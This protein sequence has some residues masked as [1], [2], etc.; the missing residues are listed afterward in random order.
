[1]TDNHSPDL[2][3]CQYTI[4]GVPA[5]LTPQYLE[6][7]SKFK[8]ASTPDEKVACLETMLRLIPKHK[9]TEK[10]Q[11]DLKR[12]LSKLRK[13]SQRKS[14]PSPRQPYY[15]IE[16]EG[17]GQAILCGPPNGGKS[18]LLD[19]LTQASPEIGDYPFTTRVPQPGMMQFEDIQIQLVDTPAL[20]P[21][22]LESWQMTMIA[23]A[24]VAV[25][26]FDVCDPQLLEQTDFVVEICEE[27]NILLNST[28]SKPR[29]VVLGN[30]LDQPLAGENFR[31]W[32]ELYQD[33]FTARP[34]S[35]RQNEHLK[36]FK[37]LL[38][39]LL[40][41]VRVYTK[42]PG[43]KRDEGSQPYLLKCGSTV[44]DAACAVHK[45]LV[46]HFRFARVWGKEG[47]EGQMVERTHIL[48]DGD[49]VEIHAGH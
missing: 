14:R 35:S 28:Q 32:S 30:K 40:G 13:G 5:N 2:T 49:L 7:E 8:R 26:L 37:L 33:R 11:A 34:F 15:H 36:E 41:I 44:L 39:S 25:L 17:A 22:F 29:A 31:A 46:D 27:H 20:A 9:G 38:F 1:M 42:R 23:E 24:D 6:A 18:H 45:D 16:R 21:D 48:E 4:E 19:K 3:T 43:Y 12:R 10:L 47:L